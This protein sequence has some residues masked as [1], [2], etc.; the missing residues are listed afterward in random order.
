MTLS[1]A[2]RSYGTSED[3]ALTLRRAAPLRALRPGG[4]GEGSLVEWPKLWAAISDALANH[5]EALRDVQ[6]ALSKWET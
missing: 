1:Y 6:E 3:E 4:G 5:P 2:R